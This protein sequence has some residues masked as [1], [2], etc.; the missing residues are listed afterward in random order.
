MI[1]IN[2]LGVPKPKRGKRGGVAMPGGD[3]PSPVLAIAIVVLIGL[4]ANGY[5]YWKLTSEAAQIAKQMGDAQAE[6]ARLA[7]VKK[8]YQEA[9]KQEAFFKKRS[10][11]I[12]KLKKSQSGPVELLTKV[13]DTV[14]KTDAVWLI[15]MKEDANN[16]NIE[17]TAL[18]ANAVANLIGNLRD[19]KYFKSVEIKETY[20]DNGVKDMQAFQFSLV[21]EKQQQKS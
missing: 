19:L 9:Q 8:Q 13:S 21:C 7:N 1:R 17:G 11:D 6:N 10:E 20:Q 4:A 3:G 15:S 12:D 16:V 5:Y 18:S 14:N 2:L